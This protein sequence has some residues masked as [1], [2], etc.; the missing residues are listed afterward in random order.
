MAEVDVLKDQ[1]LSLKTELEAVKNGMASG[2]GG[3]GP[4][5]EQL[6]Q[7]RQKVE[8]Q[9]TQMAE[10]TQVQGH[11]LS[12]PRSHAVI[13]CLGYVTDSAEVEK[14]ARQLLDESGIDRASYKYLS[15]ITR[16]GSQAELWFLDS[17]VMNQARLAIRAL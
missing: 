1:V 15:A 12:K 2:S 16:L 3:V 14:R 13:G 7:L 11:P 9:A 5:E 17:D 4:W 8:Q 10:Q 6:T